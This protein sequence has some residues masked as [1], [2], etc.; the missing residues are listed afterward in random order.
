VPAPAANCPPEGRTGAALASLSDAI[1]TSSAGA[2]SH[3]LRYP[4]RHCFLAALPM[5]SVCDRPAK[6]QDKSAVRH[7]RADAHTVIGCKCEKTLKIG[8]KEPSHRAYRRWYIRR[9]FNGLV[10]KCPPVLSP[11]LVSL[12]CSQDL[13]NIMAKKASDAPRS[14]ALP[15][16]P[17]RRGGGLGAPPQLGLGRPGLIGSVPRSRSPGK[18]RE[19][20]AG[21]PVLFRIYRSLGLFMHSSLCLPVDRRCLITGLS[22]I[23]R[24]KNSKLAREFHDWVGHEYPAPCFVACR[25]GAP[26]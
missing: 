17:G 3:T 18:S 24:F 12:W 21:R 7:P 26:P 25:R 19:P 9:H 20:L 2:S 22:Q 14:A 8:T 13:A 10:L 4:Y 6:P 15:Q 5:E 23:E 1:K 16:A 11:V